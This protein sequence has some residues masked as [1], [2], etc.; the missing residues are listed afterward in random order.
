MTFS[1]QNSPRIARILETVTIL[2]NLGFTYLYI[3]KSSLAFILGIV[4]PLLLGYLSWHRKLL[5]DVLLQCFYVLI[6]IWGFLNLNT[7]WETTSVSTYK[8]LIGMS[9]SLIAGILLGWGLKKNTKAAL[10]YFD[11]LITTFSIWSTIL[12]M[13]GCEENWVYFIFINFLCVFLF[14][15]RKLYGIAFLYFVYFYLACEGYFKLGWIPG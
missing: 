6:T 13:Y 11:S 14:L 3:Q 9:V 10:P 15:K 7:T 12:M 5:A 1:L 2:C 8:H 4:G